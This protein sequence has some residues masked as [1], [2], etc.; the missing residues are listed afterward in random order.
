MLRGEPSAQALEDRD[1]RAVTAAARRQLRIAWLDQKAV[2][3]IT[4]LHSGVTTAQGRVFTYEARS[5][6]G[7]AVDCPTRLRRHQLLGESEHRPR[8]SMRRHP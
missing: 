3:V 8:R 5:H 7:G 4:A 1:A 6:G 2:T